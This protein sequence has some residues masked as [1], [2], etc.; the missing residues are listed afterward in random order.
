MRS[1]DSIATRS[2]L[3]LI[4]CGIGFCLLLAGYGLLRLLR[5]PV[6][7]FARVIGGAIIALSLGICLSMALSA[8]TAR[9]PGG[10]SKI[11]GALS[12]LVAVYAASQWTMRRWYVWIKQQAGAWV[13]RSTRDFLVFLRTQHL[14]FGWV[15][16]AGALGHMVFFFPALAHT[17]VYEEVT[18]FV[19][20][21]ILALMVLLGL[22]LWFVSVVRKQRI[23]GVVRSVHAILAIAFFLALFLHI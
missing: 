7:Q 19:A 6:N 16:A 12:F 1:L 14:F 17:S 13:V 9:W 4:L 15:V 3:L 20:L 10:G 21:G 23:P 2:V 11:V 18:G 22:W 8:Q 5:L